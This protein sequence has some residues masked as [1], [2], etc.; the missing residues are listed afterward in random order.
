MATSHPARISALKLGVILTKRVAPIYTKSALMALIRQNGGIHFNATEDDYRWRPRFYRQQPAAGDPHYGTYSFPATNLWKKAELEIK[1][2]RMGASNTELERLLSQGR[3]T[4]LFDGVDATTKT[5]SEDFME[6]FRMDLYNDDSNSG[7]ELKLTGLESM[8][9]YSG[10]VGSGYV[11]VNDDTYAGLKTEL[12]YYGGTWSSGNIWPIGTSTTMEYSAWTPMIVDWNSAQFNVTTKKWA[13][14]WQQA[15]NF[16]FSF[17]GIIRDTKPDL[18]LIE[19]NLLREAQDSL[20]GVQGL[21]ITQNSKLTKLGH[22]TMTYN[23]RELVTEFGIPSEACYVLTSKWIELRCVTSQLLGSQE[24]VDI[25]TLQD[26]RTLGFYGN[27]VCYN[28][29]AQARLVKITS[30]T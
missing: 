14:S 17:Q 19:G 30:D 28:P 15:L 5:M 9:S 4:L 18:C 24:D 27:L 10:L 22:E 3:K 23:G 7:D 6:S 21:E 26:L 29:G 20:I 1:A 8:F 11:G 25:V 2:Y 16:T 12:G 13:N